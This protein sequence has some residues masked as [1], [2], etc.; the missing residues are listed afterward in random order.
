M[1]PIRCVMHAH[2]PGGHS[3]GPEMAGRCRGPNAD[4]VR[5]HPTPSDNHRG[6]TIL[7]RRAVHVR[8]VMTDAPRKAYVPREDLSLICSAGGRTANLTTYRPV[9]IPKGKARPVP[10][11]PL[12]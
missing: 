9:K 11:P 2:P 10:A 7:T 5:R 8:N 4:N 3:W 12:I 1:G 6:S